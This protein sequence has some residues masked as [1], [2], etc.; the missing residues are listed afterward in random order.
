MVLL[1]APTYHKY[2][3]QR[4]SVGDMNFAW[5]FGAAKVGVSLMQLDDTERDYCQDYRDH[6]SAYK[7]ILKSIY[8]LP[9]S[10]KA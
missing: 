7:V 5:K 4:E 10:Q 3:A 2:L 8:S 9:I 6:V 1:I